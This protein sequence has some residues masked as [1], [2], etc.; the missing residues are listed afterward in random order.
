MIKKLLSSVLFIASIG[1]M[2]SSAQCFPNFPTGCIPTGDDYGICPDSATGIAEGTV[3]VAYTQILSI[4]TPTTA[5]HWGQPSIQ[6]DSL[7]VTSVDSLAPGLIYQCVPSTC[8]FAGG[9]DGCILISGTPTQV[10]NHIIVV[11]ILPYV[12]IF[13]THTTYTPTTNKQYRSKV[14]L[15]SGIETIDLTRFDV[16]QNIPNPFSDKSEIQFSSV[17]NSEVEFK[18]FDM[19]GAVVYNSTIKSVKGMNTITL[20]ANLFAPGVYM[21]SIKNGEHTITKR[22]VVSSK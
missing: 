6:I 17:T 10:W 5:A 14:V 4:K 3:G 1:V 15:P 7:V 20:D 12:N 16:S 18:V 2:N 21:F 22:M 19:L 9:Q 8:A 11:N 13:G